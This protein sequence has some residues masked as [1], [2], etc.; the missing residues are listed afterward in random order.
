M[1]AGITDYET[2]PD[3]E[4]NSMSVGLSQSTET[5]LSL[6]LTSAGLLPARH[7]SKPFVNIYSS[8]LTASPFGAGFS[9][10]FKMRAKGRSSRRS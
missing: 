1:T 4:R 5:S 6:R 2:S 3:S 10:P 7:C 8:D 9:V